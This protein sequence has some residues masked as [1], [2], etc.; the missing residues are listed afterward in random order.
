MWVLIRMLRRH[1][2]RNVDKTHAAHVCRKVIDFYSP[3]ARL[4]T[5]I[6]FSPTSEHRLSTLGTLRY[7]SIRGFLLDRPDS[8]KTVRAHGWSGIP[9]DKTPCAGDNNQIIFVQSR[10]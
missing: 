10:F 7:Q 2:T 9:S 4:R 5:V 8:G 3:F 6:P 1:S